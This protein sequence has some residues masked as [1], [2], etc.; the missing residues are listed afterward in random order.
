MK[1]KSCAIL[2]CNPM[3]FPWGYDEEDERYAAL[4]LALIN[5]ITILR[6]EGVTDFYVVLDSGAGLYSAE[7]I[8]DLRENDPTIRLICVVPFET[9]ATKWMPELRDRYF[10]VQ[11]KCSD[12]L[13]ASHEEDQTRELRAMLEAINR[14]ETVIVITG[15]DDLYVLVAQQYA[16]QLKRDVTMIDTKKLQFY[17]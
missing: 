16:K 1:T 6:S 14:T 12:V 3:A 7:M 9:Q 4:K 2:G 10:D 15:G 17:G 11:A 8:A 5:R 13:I